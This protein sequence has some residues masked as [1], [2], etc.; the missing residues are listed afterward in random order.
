AA[1]L[2]L[3]W[4][5]FADLSAVT[6]LMTRIYP[7]GVADVNHF[8]AA[9][10]MGFLIR[11][12]IGAGLL[13]KDFETVAGGGLSAYARE[14][15]LKNGELAWRPAPERSS[16]TAVLRGVEDA[17]DAEGGLRLLDGPLGRSVI[18]LSAVAPEHARV[19]APALVFDSQD[20]FL[21]AF[22][23]GALERDHVAVIRFQG[24]SANGMPE[25]H[26]LTPPLSVLQ[27]KGFAVALVT[28]GR[29]SGASGKV[30]AAIHVT[31]EARQDG[32]I[33]KIRDGDII[34][35]DGPGGRLD[36]EVE[37]A[38]FAARTPA[39]FNGEGVSHGLGRE[40]FAHMR[41]G[42]GTADAGA[43]VFI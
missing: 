39:G 30:P 42:V 40:L 17:F 24:P 28:D 2:S 36:V 22:N 26:K 15:Y 9:G 37:P 33:A 8:H 10:G 23:A 13:H 41:S 11:E 38:A 27:G 12:L 5:D 32:P 25:L 6:P 16:D 31:P 1:G 14:P 19:R 29:M 4:D 3:T 34:H 7:N 20:A 21:E 43:S 35:L 18:K